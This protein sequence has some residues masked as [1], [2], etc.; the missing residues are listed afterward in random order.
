MEII[1]CATS[2][3][4]GNSPCALIPVLLFKVVAA[5]ALPHAGLLEFPPTSF[6]EPFADVVDVTARGWGWITRPAWGSCGAVVDGTMEA[7]TGELALGTGDDIDETGGVA[8][9]G[10]DQPEPAEDDC[11]DA[12]NFAV[13]RRE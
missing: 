8:D 4:V 10:R 5:F 11:S 9:G 7:P 12:V 2:A 1:P 13:T 3:A 6:C